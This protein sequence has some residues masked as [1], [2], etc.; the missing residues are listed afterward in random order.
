MGGMSAHSTSPRV[1]VG[2]GQ[3]R[4]RLG[5]V[6]ANLDRHLEFIAQAR[7][8]G[9]DLLVFPELS[10]TGYFLKDLVPVVARP[11]DTAD[12]VLGRLAEESRDMDLVVGFIERDQRYRFFV[13]TAYLSAG[14]IVHVHRKLYLPTYSMFDEGRY[15]AAGRDIGSFE[16]RFGRVGVLICE[17]FWHISPP[18]LLWL[19]GAD[20]MIHVSSSP[21]RGLSDP[22][23]GRLSSMRFV[24]DLNR[25]YAAVFT[26]FVVHVNRVGF[27]DGVNFW[28][29]SFCVGPAGELLGKAPYFEES[30]ATAQLDLAELRRVRSRLPLLRDERAELT[31]RVLQRILSRSEPGMGGG[32]F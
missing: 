12:P 27:E 6:D 28:G 10:L 8:L 24:E 25:V 7:D 4:P 22:G 21:G 32:G 15:L 18:Y 23:D 14:H 16:T 20:L 31:A 5:D 13:A 1:T 2:F 11:A 30:L 17:D 29:G 19:D 9:V 26:S 3:L